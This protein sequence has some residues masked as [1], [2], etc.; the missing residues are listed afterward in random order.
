MK[1][2]GEHKTVFVR[3][4]WIVRG[5]P[6]VAAASLLCGIV[7]LLRGDRGTAAVWL[8][9][10]LLWFLNYRWS[11]Q[12]PFA[13]VSEEGLKLRSSPLAPVKEIVWNDVMNAQLSGP[14]RLTLYLVSGH[15]YSIY[16]TWIESRDRKRL[17]RMVEASVA[18]KGTIGEGG[19][20]RSHV[21]GGRGG[22]S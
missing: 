6:A 19:F 15:R 2:A 3:N 5:M 17:V 20:D 21:S 8:L 7:F 1:C 13:V 22:E 10:T 16:L 4:S 14:S 18:E 11:R 12:N 9:M